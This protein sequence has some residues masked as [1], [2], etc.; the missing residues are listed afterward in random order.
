[1]K[2]EW[3]AV[4]IDLYKDPGGNGASVRS[5]GFS[6]YTIKIVEISEFLLILHKQLLAVVHFGCLLQ[7]NN[8]GLSNFEAE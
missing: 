2:V 3:M 6:V 7:N 1:M 4:E 5:Y 8:F